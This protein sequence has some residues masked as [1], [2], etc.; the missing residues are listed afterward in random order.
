MQPVEPQTEPRQGEP[1]RLPADP[2]AA[3]TGNVADLDEH[4]L[5]LL[6]QYLDALHRGGQPNREQLLAECPHLE[7]YLDCLHALEELAPQDDKLP[8]AEVLANAAVA[9]PL[10]ADAATPGKEARETAA[11]TAPSASRA[12][13]WQADQPGPGSSEITIP[14]DTS[15]VRLVSGSFPPAVA[16]A[17]TGKRFGA[18]ELLHEIGRGGMGV[19]YLARQAGLERYVAVKM[20]LSSHLASEEQVRR[21][22]AEAKAAA[23]FAHP[24]VVSI[25]D[26]GEVAGQHYFAMQFI[27]GQSLAQRIAAGPVDPDEA[28]RIVAVVAR[29]VHHLH[30][31]QIV[32]RDLKPGNVL[33]DRDGEPYVTDFGLAKVLASDSQHTATGIITGTPAYMSP[34]QAAGQQESVG[35]TSDVYSLG[36]IL[37]ELLTGRPPFREDNPLD[38]LVQVIERE[39]PLPRRLNPKIPV[40]L[41]LICLKCLEKQPQ[42]RYASAA[43]LADDLERYGRGEMVEAE[44]PSVRL[45][46][47]RWARREPALASRL[48]AMLLLY[49][50]ETV[51]YYLGAV[52]SSFHWL[53]TAVLVC[54]ALLSMLF[55]RLLRQPKYAQAARFGWAAT[56][57]LGQTGILLVAD[58]VASPMVIGYSLVIV[59]SGLWFRVRLVFFVTGA[60]L[61]SYS[62][63]VARYY[64][65]P[66][67]QRPRFDPDA[68]RHVYFLVGLALLGCIVAYQ[69]SR[70]RALS[71]YY[72][73]RR[74]P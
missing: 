35:P 74:C 2:P 19:V 45:R 29:A 42:D 25:F 60:C 47:W 58:G 38:T 49:S 27:D 20:I 43:D 6:Q 15:D 5:N 67:P 23:T 64:A 11:E 36:V 46:L 40:E 56:D 4:A 8:P 63:L 1:F 7:S 70:V 13:Q 39:P 66:E 24:N 48:G 51:N 30:S 53:I 26:V 65:I 73:S 21:F 68:D 72:E 12:G 61:L 59:A 50:V 28:A 55:Q 69:V 3:N 54:W 52:D 34:E 33:L 62:A 22:R 31:H 57:V 16:V 18:Y 37:Y 10:G 41:E 17:P 32:H 9:N 14:L 44:P 71:R